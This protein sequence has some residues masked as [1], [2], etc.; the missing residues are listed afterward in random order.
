[1]I[2]NA[3]GRIAPALYVVGWAKR[4]PSGTIP[5]NRAEAKTVA[6]L[7]LADFATD[8][9]PPKEGSAALDAWL[10]SRGVPVIDWAGWKR[11]ETAETAGAMPGSPRAKLCDWT[12]LR[13]TAKQS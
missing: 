3:D 9:T 2:A 10:E 4:G 5:T 1:M 11:I 6:D 7:L 13:Q 8:T 12:A